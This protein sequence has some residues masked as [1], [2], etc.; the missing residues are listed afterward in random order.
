MA[1]MKHMILKLHHI[2]SVVQMVA[3]GRVDFIVSAFRR[4]TPV[5]KL[6]FDTKTWNKSPFF[7]CEIAKNK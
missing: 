7:F 3:I 4:H 2:K 5:N 1:L 6:I